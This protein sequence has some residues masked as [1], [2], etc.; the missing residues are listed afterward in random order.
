VC[1]IRSKSGS[2]ADFSTFKGMS[3]ARK[4]GIPVR[5]P[6]PNKAKIRTEVS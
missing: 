6:N 2:I 1:G 3:T 4:N 5:T